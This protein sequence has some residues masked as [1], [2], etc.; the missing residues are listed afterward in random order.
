MEN[1]TLRSCRPLPRQARY[2]TFWTREYAVGGRPR[3]FQEAFA[4]TVLPR[5]PPC[6]RRHSSQV[7]TRQRYPRI[8]VKEY[9]DSRKILLNIKYPLML[10]VCVGFGDAF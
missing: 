7:G 1:A 8:L 3:Q 4:R 2:A 5:D 6:P 10:Q 9:R